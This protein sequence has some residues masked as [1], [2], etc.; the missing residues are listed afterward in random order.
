MSEAAAYAAGY[1]AS[2]QL[3]RAAI[4]REGMFPG[5]GNGI[6]AAQAY[7][8]ALHELE[9]HVDEVGSWFE[10]W[11]L[12]QDPEFQE[13][14]AQMQ[15]GEGIEVE[16]FRAADSSYDFIRRIDPMSDLNHKPQ[17]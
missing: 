13:S 4:A 8:S 10:S 6:L 16:T 7:S 12:S 14:L 2:L 3:L 11:H 17:A 15:S 9:Q 5:C 1:A